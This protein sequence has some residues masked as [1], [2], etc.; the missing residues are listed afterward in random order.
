MKESAGL[1]QRYST[2]LLLLIVLLGT[3]L[4]FFHLGT[5]SLWYD[6]AFSLAIADRLT[7]KEILTNQGHST[8]PPLYYLLLHAWIRVVGVNDF[9]TRVPSLLAGV[10]TIPLIYLNGR[11]LF[12]PRTGLWSALFVAVFPFHV[13]YAQEARM[14]T[15]LAL[16]TTLSLW[17][18]LR[19]IERNRR[20]A[21]GSYW[22]CLVLGIYTHYFIAFVIL[23][24]HLYLVLH[25]R[26]Y[27]HLWRPVLITDVLL[28]IAFL[29]QAAIFVRESQVVLS[30]SYWLGKPSPL[31]LF[32]TI[33]F[34]VV[35]YTVPRR[36]TGIGLFVLLSWLAIGLYEISLQ[37]RRDH[38]LRRHLALLNLGVFLPLFSALAISQ[39]KPIFLERTLIVCTPFLVLLLARTLSV[40]H[41]RSPVPYLAGALG[42]FVVISLFHLYFD[43]TMHK[44]PIRQAAEQINAEFAEGDV[45]LHT[46]VGSFLPFLFYQPP[47]EHYLLWGDPDPRLGA[48]TYEL[49]GGKIATRETIAGHR[50]LW[51]VVMLD[52]SVKYQQDQVRW[53]DD[54]FPLIE[55]SNVGGILIRLYDLSKSG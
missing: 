17:F 14:Y 47:A 29:P 42:V 9:T 32:T 45:V 1:W 25:W 39:I 43:P 24:Y 23:V 31:A 12:G 40:S 2:W 15:L 26:R 34:F 5:Q 28:L 36:L 49:F 4:R 27:R 46:G 55:D 18:F 52:H 7:L 54:H 21:W 3:A 11:K 6:E 53:F 20:T 8:H 41:L 50:R 48:A 33:Y 44:P 35:S 51:L 10:L 30:S 37:A 38:T 16:L 22:L 13:Y 19:A